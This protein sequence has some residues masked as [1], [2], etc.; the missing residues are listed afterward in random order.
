MRGADL[1]LVTNAGEL[2]VSQSSTGI[3]EGG[4]SP[5]FKVW[6][7]EAPTGDVTVTMSMGSRNTVTLGLSPAGPLTFTTSAWDEDDAQTVT[8]SVPDDNAYVADGWQRVDLDAS[9]GGYD[10]VRGRADFYFEDNDDATTVTLSASPNPVTEG[11]KVTITATLSQD[12]SADV[13][14][15]LTIPAPGGGEYTVPTNAEITITGTGTGTTG[16]L[17]IQTNQD[18]DKVDETFTVELDT[19]DTDWPSG[20]SAGDPSSVEITIYDDDKPR[21]SLS[22]TPN[23]V[24]E[25][26]KVTITATLSEDPSAD[27]T[28]PLTIPAPGGS[29]YTVPTNAEIT[30]AGTGTGTTGTLEIQTN[31]DADQDDETFTVQLDTDDTD[32]PSAYGPGTA[33]SVEITITDDDSVLELKVESSGDLVEG[34]TSPTFKVWLSKAPTGDVTVTMS[35]A[36]HNTVTLSLSPTGPLT[37]TT[38]DWAEADAQTVTVSVPD[39]NVHVAEGWQ[40][41][42]LE[43]SGGGA[44]RLRGYA[45]FYFED[46]DEDTGP[47]VSLS[48]SPNPVTEGSAVTITAT[49]SEDPDSDVTIP[50]TIPAPGGGEYTVPTNAEITIAGAG[51]G[52]TGT[53]DIQTNQDSDKD[54]ETFTV[55]LD[56]DDDDWPSDWSAG[57]PSSVEITISDDDK[58]T[59]SLSA[60]PNPVDEGSKVTITATLSEDPTSDVTIPLTIPAPGGSEYTVPT[61]AEITIAG[62]G[63]GTTGT[64]EIQTNEDADLDDETFTVELDTDDTDWPSAYNAGTASSVEITITDN[65]EAVTLK[66]SRSSQYLDEGGTSPTFKVWLSG[67]PTGDVSVTMTLSDRNTV[68]LGLNPAGPLTFTTSAWD[69]DDAQTVTVSV[70]DNTIDE[71][72][73]WQAIFLEG[74][75]GGVDTG[76]ERVLFLFRDNDEAATVTLSASPNPVTEGSKVTI[77]ATLSEDPTSDVTIPL[78][79][80]AAGDGEYTV[81][82]NAEITIAGAGTG[83]TGTLDIQT[84]EDADSVDET[85]T[86]ELGTEDADWPSAYGAGTAS[87]VEITITDNDKPTVDLSASPNPVDEGSAVTI[88][89]TLSEDPSADVTIPLT[90][91]AP[92]DGEFTS[93]STAEITI[94]GAGT[95]TTGT[96]VIQTNEDADRVDETFTVELDTDD[97][98]WPSGVS[99]GDP[100][101][102]E[103]T[104]YDDDK[105]RVSL[106][107]TPNPVDEGSKVTITATLSED[108]SADVT[109]PLTIP[110]PGGSEYTVPT[111]AEITIAGTGTGTTGTLAIQTNEDS[112]KVD[113]TFTVELATG[114]TDWPSTY[115]T[116]TASSVAITITD[117]DKPELE[118]G[119]S[120]TSLNEGG[121]SQTFSVKLTKVPSADVTITLTLATENT[122]ALT[123]DPSGPLTFTTDN[124]SEAQ[125]VTVSVLDNTIIEE[126]R[127]QHIDLAASG[128]AADGKKARV[129]FKF[130]DNDK[131]DLEV[132][133]SSQGL[134]EGGSSLTFS[135]KL[136]KVPNADVTV[137]LSPNTANTVALTLDPSG[138]LTFTTDNWS[139]AQTVTVSVA[140]NTIIE[141]DAYQRIDLAA[142]GGGADGKTAQVGFWY[143]DNDKPDLE[144]SQSDPSAPG[145]REGGDSQTFSVKLTKVPNADVTV[146]LTP[147]MGNTVALTLDPSG[148]L[149]FTTDNWSQAQTVTVSVPDNSI[150]EDLAYQYIDL[151]ASGGGVADGTTA[152]AGWWYYDND[153]PDLEVASQSNRTLYEGGDSETFSVRL[154]KVPNADVTV[155]LTPRTG[156]TVA[157]TLDPSGPLTFTTDNWSEAQTVTVSVPDN[158]ILVADAYQRIELAGSGGGADGKIASVDFLVVDNDKPDLEV[159]QS[160][161]N[162]VEGGSPE[163]FS[164]NLTRAPIA[165]VTVTLTLY[166]GNSVALTLD[167]LGPLTFTTDNWSEAQTVEVSVPDNATIEPTA[168]QRID[169]AASGGGADGKTARVGFWFYDGDDLGLQVSQSGE[170]LIE[171]GDSETFSVNLTKEPGAN[172]TVTLAL[173]TGNSVALAL[174]PLGPLTFTPDTWSQAQTVSVSVPDN[175]TIEVNAFQRINLVASGGGADGASANVDFWVF[176]NDASTLEVTLAASP[177]PVDEGAAVT[178]TATL[179]ETPTEDVVIP[180]AFTPVT[181]EPSDYG[182]LTTG[183]ITILGAGNENSGTLDIVTFEDDSEYDDETFTVA[184]GVL[185]TGVVAGDPFLVEI[186]IEDN[187]VR[188][189]TLSASPNPVDEGAAVTIT[190]TLSEVPTTDVVI[191]LTISPG[192]AEPSDYG[193]LTAG[194]LSRFLV[195]GTRIPE[196]WTLLRLRMIV[197]TTMRRSQWHSVRCPLAC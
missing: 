80:P 151:A 105:P 177:N 91:P 90:I 191:P 182:G 146:T 181:A 119:Q 25:G 174:D 16:T 76:S 86:V 183:S 3:S 29:E 46:N 137:T 73:G 21:V 33:S 66:F 31:Q 136:T 124:W 83:T 60:S 24:D 72:N 114:D 184:L 152:Q 50:L 157:L 167:P 144:V 122:V 34:G 127:T 26:S 101:S 1:N 187:D 161:P 95:G 27:V 196:R 45:N 97:T 49:L 59:V 116:G 185:P 52:T 93:P 54:D 147:R 10:R 111:N 197:S 160:S 19:D 37:F 47:T 14:I 154:T 133:Q 107:A 30:I 115:G 51:T 57:D 134:N 5:T 135:V 123:L 35:P 41:V 99:A 163:T 18:S 130:Y 173:D 165:D 56:T 140:D 12:P 139:E 125:S 138:S 39:D 81:P 17:E 103:I 171:G 94:A 193:G 28:I 64:L 145:L 158:T 96:L 61:N 148:P 6:L 87:S 176:D 67:E 9:G 155:T 175:T 194:T 7:S 100:S 65:D 190:A 15:P 75:G 36:S 2:K 71:S 78:T 156:N 53:L 164:V 129:A 8:V 43:A 131:P 40:R 88:T 77:T 79:I 23:P 179:S 180:L 166:T 112:D 70:P 109:I 89:A 42:N 82:T 62:T 92:V 58:P 120:A 68:T 141:S 128:G 170:S 104:I 195:R 188:T 118:V 55:E 102:V 159:S 74:S 132:S 110:A 189:V 22:A 48:A 11:S 168:Y 162:I 84:N 149:T 63:T 38:S 4:T 32:W 121:D 108:P 192:T 142:S 153:K 172:V 98:D 106:S 69:E 126:D 113:E 143:Y 44:D 85:F 150:I 186:T 169:L 178:I 13:T 117:N 20:V